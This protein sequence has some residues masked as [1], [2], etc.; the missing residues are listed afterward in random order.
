MAHTSL[1]RCATDAVASLPSIITVC[2]S[3]MDTSAGHSVSWVA[4]F[5]MA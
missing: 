1:M 2:R 4:R 5:S 3:V